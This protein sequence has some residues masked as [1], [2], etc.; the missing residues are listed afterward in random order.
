M[1]VISAITRFD[2]TGFLLQN[3]K[4]L[5]KTKLENK[6][7]K[8]SLTHWL[9]LRPVDAGRTHGRFMSVQNERATLEETSRQE[10]AKQSDGEGAEN[11]LKVR[12]KRAAKWSRVRERLPK[13]F[14][15]S[16]SIK[17]LVVAN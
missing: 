4:Q 13:T 11:M 8:A 17:V 3:R 16:C 5:F 2:S 1:P 14:V 6:C 9:S 7:A 10:R 12:H 15:S